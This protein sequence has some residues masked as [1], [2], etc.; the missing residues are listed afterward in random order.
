VD[1]NCELPSNRTNPDPYIRFI[2]PAWNEGSTTGGEAVYSNISMLSAGIGANLTSSLSAKFTY[3]LLTADETVAGAD[4]DFG[5]YY[6][7]QT[8]Y[9]YSKNLSFAMYAALIAPGDAFINDDDAYEFFIET[10]LK[11]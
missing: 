1:A 9:G 3:G 11:F 8:K 4:D 7:L 10:N 2:R 6:Q 5:D